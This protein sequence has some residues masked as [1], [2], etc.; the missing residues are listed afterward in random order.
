MLLGKSS[1]LI[2]RN[3]EAH[4]QFM[5]VK[6]G[7]CMWLPLGVNVSGGSVVTTAWHGTARSLVADE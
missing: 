3:N 1:L 5:D 2:V 4:S 7:R 6:S